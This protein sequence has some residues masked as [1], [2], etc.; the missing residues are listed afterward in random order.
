[1]FTL[2]T[3]SIASAG[4]YLAY[5]VIRPGFARSQ[6]EKLNAYGIGVW[7]VLLILAVCF[8]ISVAERYF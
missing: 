8:V 2:F 3:L 7:V 5:R 1:M 4:F 6:S